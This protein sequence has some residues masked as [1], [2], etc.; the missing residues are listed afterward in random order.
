MAKLKFLIDDEEE[1]IRVWLG[2]EEIAYANHD[3]HGWG[4]IALLENAVKDIAA[5]LDMEVEYR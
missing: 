2:D 1:S 4:G 5:A 3:E